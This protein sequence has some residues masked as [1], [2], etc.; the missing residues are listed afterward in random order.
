MIRRPPR[1]TL[2]PY[3]TL[4]RSPVTL[5]STSAYALSVIASAKRISASS[6]PRRLRGTTVTGV[7]T[8]QHSGGRVPPLGLGEGVGVGG[9]ADAGGAAEVDVDGAADV[10]AGDVGVTVLGTGVV[11]G[12]GVGVGD[13]VAQR[14]AVAASSDTVARADAK[15][16]TS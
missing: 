2:F 16:G 1:S 5:K 8:A 12:V 10:D 14:S 6:T 4:F 3:T 7:L 11:D 15:S 9:E 13:G